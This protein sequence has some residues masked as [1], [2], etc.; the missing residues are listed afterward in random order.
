[1]WPA[2]A[3]R[4]TLG[5]ACL[6]AL[7]VAAGVHARPGAVQGRGQATPPPP[8]LGLDHGTLTFDTPD[9]TLKLV[10]DSQT[11]AALQPK[12]ARGVDANTPFDFT[13]A[14]QLTARQGDHFN[15]LGDITLRIRQAG[16][17][18]GTWVD[19]ASSDARKPVGLYE[20]H[21]GE[22]AGLLTGAE[23][24]ANVASGARR[25]ASVERGCSMPQ[26]VSS[27]VSN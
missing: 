15:H 12:G 20:T 27:C 11:I 24:H 17:R 23:S 21:P 13:P 16:W 19:F 2:P 10:K 22:P 1:M 14:D 7:A 5:V 6:A 3:P 26:A 9:F 18:D 8:T 4:T 25:C